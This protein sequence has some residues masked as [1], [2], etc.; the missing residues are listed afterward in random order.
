M[1]RD[2]KTAIDGSSIVHAELQGL[3][4]DDH[5]QYVL[6]VGVDRASLNT[7]AP[8]EGDVLRY[9]STAKIWINVPSPTAF[10]YIDSTSGDIYYFD[11]TRS[12]NLGVATIQTDGSRN[13]NRVTNVYLRGEGNTPSNLNGFVLPWNATLIG[14]S[15]SSNVNTQ[16]WSAQVRKNGATSPEDFLTSVNLYSKQSSTNNVD[17]NAGDRVEIFCSGQNIKYPKGSLFFRRRF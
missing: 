10:V 1:L 12:K 16:T 9:D 14:I 7:E 5:K 4:S 15:M 17:F 11:P 8:K 13:K 3:N 6:T 2:T